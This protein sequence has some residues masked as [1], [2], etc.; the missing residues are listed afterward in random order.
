MA[1]HSTIISYADDTTMVSSHPDLKQLYLNANSLVD[2]LYTWYCA[3]KLSLNAGKTKYFVIRP[4]YKKCN[5]DNFILSIN[6][7]PLQRI[8]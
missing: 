3:N 5:L 8:G 4:K 6:G 7:I 2:K 1:C